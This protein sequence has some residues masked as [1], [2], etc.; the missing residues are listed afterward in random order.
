[1]RPR[2]GVLV[3]VLVFGGLYQAT[4][5]L[6]SVAPGPSMLKGDFPSLSPHNSNS[7]N[8][9]SLFFDLASFSKSPTT[10]S[11]LQSLNKEN[12]TKVSIRN[13][14]LRA[15]SNNGDKTDISHSVASVW[16]LEELFDEVWKQDDESNIIWLVDLI[17]D[18][19]SRG[20][21]R[22]YQNFL[23]GSRSAQDETA[24]GNVEATYHNHH[25]FCC[26]SD[27]S[28]ACTVALSNFT[29]NGTI[30]EQLHRQGSELLRGVHE[31]T[32]AGSNRAV[33]ISWQ[34]SKFTSE[35]FVFE[36]LDRHRPA[37]QQIRPK[38]IVLGQGLHCAFSPKC[39]ELCSPS[40]RKRLDS[41]IQSLHSLHGIHFA[42]DT[43]PIVGPNIQFNNSNWVNKQTRSLNAMVRKSYSNSTN[44]DYVWIRDIE[45]WSEAFHLYNPGCIS[46]DDI[47]IECLF[48][49]ELNVGLFMNYVGGHL[50][51]HPHDPS[52]LLLES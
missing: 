7:F 9:M 2:F 19:F 36:H 25:V 49:Q 39:F 20:Q 40:S 50:K 51:L 8:N 35:E 34:W 38:S 32:E 3:S 37:D 24:F 42:V 27:I 26:H 10:I 28:K 5:F 52:M 12:A 48:F 15:L 16:E 31:S 46:G 33:C 11:L 21:Y 23:K 1:M 14:T 6:S 43:A 30:H 29:F 47:H 13:A 18:S 45:P 41:T 22:V 17:G 44:K 4:Q